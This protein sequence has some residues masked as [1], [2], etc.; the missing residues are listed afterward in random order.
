MENIGYLLGDRSRLLRRAFDERVR[1]L[2]VT[3]P[4]ARLLF[5][6]TRNEGENQGFYAEE[7]D[8]EPITLCRMVDRLEESGMIERRRSPADRRAWQLFLTESSRNKI[9]EMR[10]CIDQLLEEMLAGI[11]PDERDEFARIL[12]AIGVNLGARRDNKVSID[13]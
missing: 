13:G 4:Q 3:G 8:V 6:L 2:G 10:E 1:A 9:P 11:S 7:L 12:T 5:Y